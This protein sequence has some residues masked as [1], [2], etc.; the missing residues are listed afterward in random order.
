MTIALG[1]LCGGGLI[2]AADT[3]II[4]NDGSKTYACKLHQRMAPSGCFV[5]AAAT[6]DGNAATTLIT[7]TLDELEAK[8]PK[9][10]AKAE[11]IVQ[12]K[13]TAW[14]YAFSQ[15]PGIQMVFG[16]FVNT[17]SMPGKNSG[18]GLA[19]YFCEPPNTIVRKEA[20]DNSRG[21]V[22]IGTGAAVTDPLYKT[23]FA[24]LA[25]AQTRLKEISYLMY[26]AKKDNANCDGR[27]N[28]VFLKHAYE[29]PLWVTPLDMEAAEHLGPRFDFLLHTLAGAVFPQP[30]ESATKE[31]ASNFSV[32][33]TN[34]AAPYIAFTFKTID[35][36]ENP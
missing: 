36:R 3:A 22:A 26:R 24:S 9:T 6:L 1:V 17:V 10:L 8:D 18:G 12:E 14:S 32:M 35:A 2:V 16:A 19:L 20:F 4:A 29:P 28:A 30:N 34:A 15:P 13:M 21:Y 25:S 5:I 7:Q 31:F 33:I 27:T 23:F 11:Q